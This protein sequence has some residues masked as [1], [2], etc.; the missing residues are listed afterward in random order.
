[1][2]NLSAAAVQ[3]SLMQAE[4]LRAVSQAARLNLAKDLACALLHMY[5]QGSV[6]TNPQSGQLRDAIV[7]TAVEMADGLMARL[8]QPPRAARTADQAAGVVRGD[9]KP[10]GFDP[11]E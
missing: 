5:G 8:K 10:F 9:S 11:P 1:M 3:A 7:E 4:A 6:L 2:A